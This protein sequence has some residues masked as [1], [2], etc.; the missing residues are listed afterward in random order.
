MLPKIT[1]SLAFCS[2]NIHQCA[3]ILH[4][5]LHG[6]GNLELIISVLGVVIYKGD[7]EGMKRIEMNRLKFL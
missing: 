2:I 6:H 3:N 1:K 7:Y 4:H 5:F